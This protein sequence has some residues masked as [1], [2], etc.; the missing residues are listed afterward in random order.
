MAKETFET[1]MNK[2]EEIVNKLEKGD[3]DLDESLKLYE[4]GLKLS[5][6]LKHELDKFE[7]KI[8]EL[9]NQDEQ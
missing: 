7:K 4:D 8:E 5:K 2:L 3:T 6:V 1:Q 9:S